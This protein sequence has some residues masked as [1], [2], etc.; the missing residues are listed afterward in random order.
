MPVTGSYADIKRFVYDLETSPRLFIIENLSWQRK[1]SGGR[2]IPKLT[3][4]AHIL[5]PSKLS[6]SSIVDV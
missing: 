2:Y 5:I 4:A 3:V 6:L 1:G